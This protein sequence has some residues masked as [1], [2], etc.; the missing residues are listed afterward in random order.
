M[1]LDCVFNS[2]CLTLSGTVNIN[3]YAWGFI[4]FY[5][6]NIISYIVNYVTEIFLFC[7]C[8]NENIILPW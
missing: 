4:N 1:C 8:P 6:H 2:F 5:N 7:K 3:I